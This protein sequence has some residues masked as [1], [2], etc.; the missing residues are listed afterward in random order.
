V[1]KLEINKNLRSTIAPSKDLY[2]RD[3]RSNLVNVSR[4]GL[5]SRNAIINCKHLSDP[6]MPAYY[7]NPGLISASGVYFPEIFRNSK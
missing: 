6:L 2:R 7:E 1:I 3:V 5:F 4:T